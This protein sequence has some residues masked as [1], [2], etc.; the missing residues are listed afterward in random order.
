MTLSFLPLLSFRHQLRASPVVVRPRFPLLGGA[1]GRRGEEGPRGGGAPL[2]HRGLRRRRP[3]E[4]E[5]RVPPIPG[6]Q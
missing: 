1:D 5:R 6:L 2:L 4:E 3:V